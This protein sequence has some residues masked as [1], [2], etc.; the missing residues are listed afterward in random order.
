MKRLGAD[1][2]IGLWR[3]SVELRE[4]AAKLFALEPTSII[5]LSRKGPRLLQL[6]KTM[7]IL[8][9]R[10]EIFADQALDF[11]SREDVGENP[12]ITTVLLPEEY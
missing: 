11:V 12:V 9:P 10:V 6:M 2:E 7:G 5:A 3:Y 4:A 8:V 1:V